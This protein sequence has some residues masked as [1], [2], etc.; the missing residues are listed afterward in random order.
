MPTAEGGS[1]ELFP[2]AHLCRRPCSNKLIPAVQA[3][4]N[5]ALPGFDQRAW[6]GTKARPRWMG[7]PP[8]LDI[9]DRGAEAKPGEPLRLLLRAEPGA[10][11]PVLVSTGAAGGAAPRLEAYWE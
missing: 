10:A 9:D 6:T 2:C 11:E 3:A 4:R 5:C 8:R 7:L 1:Q